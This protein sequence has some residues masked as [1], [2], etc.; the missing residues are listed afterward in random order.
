[1]SVVFAT[2]KADKHMGRASLIR[3]KLVSNRSG[4]HDSQSDALSGQYG[5]RGA[6]AKR[7]SQIAASLSMLLQRRSVL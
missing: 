6:I 1:M 7:G 3:T 2:S 4:A 5:R